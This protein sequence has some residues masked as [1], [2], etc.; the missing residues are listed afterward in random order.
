MS[1]ASMQGTMELR[2]QD[3]K[4]FKEQWANAS[5][6]LKASTT[7]L[8]EII[9][10]H[11]GKGD[12][13]IPTGSLKM[14]GMRAMMVTGF[15][16]HKSSVMK[17]SGRELIPSIEMIMLEV[18]FVE[19]YRPQLLGHASIA[20]FRKE[21]QNI[22]DANLTRTQLNI[23]G[24]GSGGKKSAG[25]STARKT[26][27]FWDSVELPDKE[28]FD[29]HEMSI[30]LQKE[31]VWQQELLASQR[32]DRDTILKM[33]RQVSNLGLA[34]LYPGK[35]SPLAKDVADALNKLTEVS[36]CPHFQVPPNAAYF[37]V[38]HH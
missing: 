26:W 36:R 10:P 15:D 11:A 19:K 21:L 29:D 8:K 35:K 13:D 30:E 23:V 9:K 22:M 25:L 14:P 4:V 7:A 28:G 17:N 16:W 5:A 37:A 2:P 33:Q 20:K 12:V 1:T 27:A 24:A 18:A 34:R 31:Q 32:D 38:V 6:P 3:K